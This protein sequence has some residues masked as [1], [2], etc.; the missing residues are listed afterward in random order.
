MGLPERGG[1]CSLVRPRGLVAAFRRLLPSQSRWLC[2]SAPSHARTIEYVIGLALSPQRGAS[3]AKPFPRSGTWRGSCASK[4]RDRRLGLLHALV[5][6]RPGTA[7]DGWKGGSRLGSSQ[8]GA[9]CVGGES[10][11]ELRYCCA[12]LCTSALSRG[13]GEA[14]QHA[15][16][17]C[18]TQR[19]ER[20]G[21]K[22]V[23]VEG[24][25]DHHWRVELET[26]SKPTVGLARWSMARMPGTARAS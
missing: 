3:A 2:S 16:V 22:G 21:T 8:A 9:R 19:W 5:S 11:V 12:G 1:R 13:E 24:V 10:G 18:G 4:R 15:S 6:K 20:A 23:G 17:R 25:R 7:A 14:S 26:K